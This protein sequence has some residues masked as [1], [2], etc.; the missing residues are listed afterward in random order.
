[1]GSKVLEISYDKGIN[2]ID[3]YCDLMFMRS[4]FKQITWSVV[5]VQ[6]EWKQCLVD[7]DFMV[8]FR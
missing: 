7:Q 8:H 1:M 6:R 5:L 3:F 2:V 4:Y